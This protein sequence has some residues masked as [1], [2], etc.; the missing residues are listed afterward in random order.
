MFALLLSWMDGPYKE[1]WQDLCKLVAEEKN[2]DRFGELVKQLL[3][4]LSKKDERLKR[5][6]ETTAR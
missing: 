1:R 2:S 5:A 6:Q 3:E 4:E